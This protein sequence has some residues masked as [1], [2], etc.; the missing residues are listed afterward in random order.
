MSFY[1]NDFPSTLKVLSFSSKVANFSTLLGK[2]RLTDSDSS[3]MSV[4]DAK[5]L[6]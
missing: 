6:S 5:E 3:Y 1:V 4:S 2:R